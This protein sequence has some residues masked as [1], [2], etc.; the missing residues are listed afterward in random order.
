[1]QLH[2]SLKFYFLGQ[3]IPHG[4]KFQELHRLSC[5][6]IMIVKKRAASP[7]DEIIV[8]AIWA[9][10]KSANKPKFNNPIGAQPMHTDSTPINRL[11]AFLG[12]K[13]RTNVLCIAPNPAMPNPATHKIETPKKY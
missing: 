13:V 6:I 9:P 10:N 4:I 5:G 1:M 8:N 7:T 12:A 11:L 3:K 2:K